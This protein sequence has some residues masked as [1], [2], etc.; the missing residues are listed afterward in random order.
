MEDDEV[1]GVPQNMPM[2]QVPQGIF[3]RQPLVK[4]KKKLTKKQLSKREKKIKH[5]IDVK[6]GLL[7]PNTPLKQL[8]EDEHIEYQQRLVNIKNINIS[9]SSAR[10]GLGA[11]TFPN[12][13]MEIPPQYPAQPTNMPIGISAPVSSGYALGGSGQIIPIPVM[14]QY[15]GLIGESK[16]FLRIMQNADNKSADIPINTPQGQIPLPTEK[17]DDD[18]ERGAG[19]KW[20]QQGQ[21]SGRGKP[22]F[23]DEKYI[24][25]TPMR[26]KYEIDEEKQRQEEIRQKHGKKKTVPPPQK[27]DDIP[28]L[29]VIP[30]GTGASARMTRLQNEYNLNKDKMQKGGL[31]DGD[32]AELKNRMGELAKEYIQETNENSQR[33]KDSQARYRGRERE[34]KGNLKRSKS[35]GGDVDAMEDATPKVRFSSQASQQESGLSNMNPNPLSIQVEDL[36]PVLNEDAGRLDKPTEPSYSPPEGMRLNM[37]GELE[38]I[39]TWRTHGAMPPPPPMPNP[40][41][42]PPPAFNP[43]FSPKTPQEK[44]D[45]A[46]QQALEE[47]GLSPRSPSLPLPDYSNVPYDY[48]SIADKTYQDAVSSE[49]G[50]DPFDVEDTASSPH[51]K[52]M[53]AVERAVKKIDDKSEA[54][55]ASEYFRDSNVDKKGRIKG[56]GENLFTVDATTGR[57]KQGQANNELW[58]YYTQGLGVPKGQEKQKWEDYKKKGSA[59]REE[60]VGYGRYIEIGDRYQ[61]AIEDEPGLTRQIFEYRRAKDRIERRKKKK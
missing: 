35:Q 15:G 24:G 44:A 48:S 13:P 47:A 18:T 23:P 53:G 9:R 41:L 31:S 39:P 28:S 8:T 52:P 25:P 56:G 55:L 36:T 21:S 45:A 17:V 49:F 32:N 7:P 1:S 16:N 2:Q 43:T 19:I 59:G 22:S 4:K 27:M 26:S 57:A 6:L 58:W 30:T 12:P 46:Y 34:K 38:P 60:G 14:P 37:G 51:T 10:S 54:Q 3:Q 40:P 61:Q 50:L 5:N 42:P 33:S 11:I 20:L 29:P